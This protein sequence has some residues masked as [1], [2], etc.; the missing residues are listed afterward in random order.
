MY[1]NKWSAPTVIHIR[2]ANISASTLERRASTA[3]KYELSRLRAACVECIVTQ[4][5]GTRVVDGAALN[6]R[7]R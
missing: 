4:M 5:V 7:R 2:D 3:H 6:R 1:E